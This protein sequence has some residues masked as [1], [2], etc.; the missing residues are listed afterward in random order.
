MNMHYNENLTYECF[1]GLESVI[2][3]SAR[4]HMSGS[5]ILSDSYYYF[6]FF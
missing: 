6:E 3:I 4:H 5:S 2:T 1:L